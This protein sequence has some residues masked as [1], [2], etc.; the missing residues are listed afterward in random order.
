MKKRLLLFFVM[1]IVMLCPITVNAKSE[2]AKVNDTVKKYFKMVKKTDLDGVNKMAYSKKYKIEDTKGFK[3]NKPILKYIKKYNKKITYKILSTSVKGE[4]ATVKL[5]VKYVDS[6]D[7]YSNLFLI[8]FA[9]AFAEVNI[10]TDEYMEKAWNRA[11]KMSNVKMKSR[12]ITVK[13][14]K[15]NKKWLIK[16]KNLANIAVA[17]LIHSAEQ[18]EE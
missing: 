1:I 2:K 11:V 6:T 14:Q 18:L 8:V 13:F 9:D 4:N 15:K 17:D 10:D 5:R 3:S 7:V 16:S 12:T